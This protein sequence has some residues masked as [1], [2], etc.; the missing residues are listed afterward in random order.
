[1]TKLGILYIMV[2]VLVATERKIC[3]KRG[4]PIVC[5]NGQRIIKKETCENSMDIKETKEKLNKT[6]GSVKE[7]VLGKL[8]AISELGKRYIKAGAVCAAILTAGIVIS[9]NFT[10]VYSVY[11]GGEFVGKVT[12]KSAFEAAYADVN[13]TIS[14]LDAPHE[15]IGFIPDYIYGISLRRSVTD[16]YA[17]KSNI[18]NL[19]RAVRPACYISVDGNSVLCVSDETK[20]KDVIEKIRLSYGGED[21]KIVSDVA[22][23]NGFS[24]IRDITDSGL[25]GMN[26]ASKINVETYETIVYDEPVPFGIEYVNN[27][28][29][30]EGQT[31]SVS[32]GTNGSRTVTARVTKINGIE[33]ARTEISSAETV[34][35]VAQV[36]EIGTKVPS[37]I[38]N[39]S[40]I[41]PTFGMVTSRFGARWGR[42]HNG[43]DI[44]NDIGTPVK[45]ADDGVV[46]H[47]GYDGDFGNLIIINHNNGYETYYAHLNSMDV[48]EGQKIIQGQ[49]IG[50]VG[51]TGYSTGPHLHFE[52]RENGVPTDPSK[53]LN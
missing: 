9:V 36:I 3:V 44:A 40:F 12:A 28:E 46:T 48:A 14:K 17:L 15:T 16:E 51:N 43:L 23:T 49:K 53:Y 18:A 29:M 35:A 1:M 39:G 50:E 26:L 32:G 22:F 45:A 47:A 5:D 4:C 20:A 42:R 24:H 10:P 25:A 13:E 33:T 11:L 34:M 30:Y 19:S 41:D 52:V 2:R 27:A 38:G 21:A 37:G 6:Y 7:K 31:K 8:H